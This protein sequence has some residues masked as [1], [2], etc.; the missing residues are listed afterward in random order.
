[1]TG[2]FGKS[3]GLDAGALWSAREAR[4]ASTSPFYAVF[5]TFVAVQRLVEVRVSSRNARRL[6]DRGAIELA[7]EQL[8]WMIAL[9]A[10]LLAACPLEVVFAGRPLVPAVAAP[11][12]ALFA[13]AELLRLSAIRALGP[14]WSIRVI[15]VPGET[16]VAT[17][18]YR[19][20]RHPNYLAV[21]VEVAAIP[22][23]HGAW[24]TA[25]VASA[26]NAWLL[27]ARIRVEDEALR[28]HASR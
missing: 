19:W 3:A 25:A 10:A 9:H 5:L 24:I 26:A 1:V 11:A 15:V 20:L 18:P 16:L 27:A 13:A 12:A 2:T 7:R 21:A 17:G 14:R 28:A 6:L 23:I 4:I 8:P 22:M